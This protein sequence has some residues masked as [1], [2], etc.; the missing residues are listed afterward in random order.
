MRTVH[1]PE[2]PAKST[3]AN[4][5][6]PP[7]KKSIKLKLTNGNGN[8]SANRVGPE[9][10]PKGAPSDMPRSLDPNLP[11]RTDTNTI[12]AHTHDENGDPIPASHQTHPN[13][14]IAYIPAH[15]PITG[16]PGF[17]ITYPPDIHFTAW[18]SSIAADQLM[19]LLRRQLH[20][21]QKEQAELKRECAGLERTRGEEFQLK[22]VLLDG[23]LEAELARGEAEGL[24]G[25]VDGRTRGLM[26][27]DA[28]M[29]KG[30]SWAGGTPK[31]RR[32]RHSTNDSNFNH[33][34]DAASHSDDDMPDAADAPPELE[35]PIDRPPSPQRTPSPPPTG[36]SGGFDG[37]ADPYDN[38]LAGR[39][40]EYEE[41]ERLRSSQNTPQKVRKDRQG[42]REREEVREREADAVGALV[43][44]S[45]K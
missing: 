24:L 44:M 42:V 12:A 2:A 13:D 38:Y 25:N 28:E 19:R 30:I 39:M 3:T 33:A 35:T 4:D 21:A 26:E 34:G 15:H 40:A 43:G 5:P 11:T 14:N 23:V 6:T 10:T 18:E 32:T 8:A 31:W 36:H 45:G 27:R 7:G 22:E 1:E 29:G 16:Q 9:G 37:D 17:M 41:R 20:W